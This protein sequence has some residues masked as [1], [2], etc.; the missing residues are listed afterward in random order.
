MAA[1]RDHPA[2]ALALY[3]APAVALREAALAVAVLLLLAVVDRRPATAR[4][5]LAGAALLVVANSFAIQGG[6][7]TL[8]GLLPPLLGFAAAGTVTLAAWFG[9]AA[10]LSVAV[11]KAPV[12][13]APG[14]GPPAPLHP[15]VR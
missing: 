7:S 8:V 11:A 13:R 12:S 5:G 14:A 2:E 15:P 6:V 10:L 4:A 3:G 1:A 9:G